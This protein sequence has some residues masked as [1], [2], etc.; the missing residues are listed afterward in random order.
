MDGFEKFIKGLRDDRD[1]PEKV[2]KQY[3]DTLADLPKERR[4][5]THSGGV[6]LRG[7]QQDWRRCWDLVFSVW[8]IR[9]RRKSFH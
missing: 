2:R 3:E 7:W 9:Q 6:N 1:I 4:R 8:E 5:E